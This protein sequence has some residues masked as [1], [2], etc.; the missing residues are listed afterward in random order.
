MKIKS[1]RSTKKQP[2]EHTNYEYLFVLR[3]FVKNSQFDSVKK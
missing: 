3:T 2:Y 1:H